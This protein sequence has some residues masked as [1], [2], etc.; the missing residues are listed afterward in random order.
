MAEMGILNISSR[1]EDWRAREL[2]NL[3]KAEFELNEE[4]MSS[5]EG[6]IQGIK[7]PENH[8]GRQHALN[9]VGFAA[10]KL[11]KQI[12]LPNVFWQGQMIPYGS[13]EHHQ[14]I[15]RAIRACYQQN[16]EKMKALL[17]TRGMELIHDLGY[18]E[19]PKTSLPSK[20][21]CKILTDIREENV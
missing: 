19:S 12:R 20:L 5:I 9:S 6:F 8:L 1:S 15:A 10:K 21:F 18:P 14:L 3:P 4:K 11:G 16:P 7:F 2:S 17:A 13:D